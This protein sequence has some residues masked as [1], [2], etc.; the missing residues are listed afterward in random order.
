MLSFGKGGERVGRKSGV[1][2]KRASHG[3]KANVAGDRLCARWGGHWGRGRCREWVAG[4]LLIKSG[5]GRCAERRGGGDAMEKFQS[6]F[7]SAVFF[8]LDF[9]F[10]SNQL[11]RKGDLGL[12]LGTVVYRVSG[13]SLLLK[14]IQSDT[15]IQ[16]HS[17]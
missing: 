6:D 1:S 12:R 3:A 15:Y 11:W 8:L 10:I 13:H 17:G 7:N 4:V 16:V 5:E 9:Q 2:R 14:G